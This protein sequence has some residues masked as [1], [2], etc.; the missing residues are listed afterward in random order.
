MTNMLDDSDEEEEGV[1]ILGIVLSGL[2]L[3]AAGLM[4]WFQV[5]SC[6]LWEGLNQLF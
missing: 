3:I 6:E 4:V 2:G 5:Q 1:D